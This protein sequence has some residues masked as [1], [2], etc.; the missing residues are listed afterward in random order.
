MIAAALECVCF[1]LPVINYVDDVGYLIPSRRL[2]MAFGN[3]GVRGHVGVA[4]KGP[5]ATLGR[6]VAFLGVYGDSPPLR[7]ECFCVPN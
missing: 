6:S 4:L 2:K 7:L 3:S 1:G 5:W